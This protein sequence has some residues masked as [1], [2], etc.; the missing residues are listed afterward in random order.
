[1][2]CVPGSGVWISRPGPRSSGFG[3]LTSGSDFKDPGSGIWDLGSGIRLWGF[4]VRVS[5]SGQHE[6]F[7]SR[8]SWVS[9]VLRPGRLAPASWR[10]AVRAGRLPA[11]AP[12]RSRPRLSM[13]KVDIRLPGKGDSN[14]HGARPVHQIISM[15]KWIRTCRLSLHNF[16]CPRLR[17]DGDFR[18]FVFWSK[19][20]PSDRPSGVTSLPVSVFI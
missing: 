17:Q 13:R 8:V 15:T 2:R 19:K 6:R 12:A 1:M 10:S 3:F 4:M 20:A 7:R 14:S 11:T 9:C 5:C 18:F 16:L